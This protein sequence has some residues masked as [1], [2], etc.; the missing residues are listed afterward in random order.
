RHTPQGGRVA[1][2]L[3]AAEDQVAVQ[4]AD[5]GCGIAA[6]ELPHVFDRFYQ[7]NKSERNA[8]GGV[9]LGLAISKRIL[10]LHASTIAVNSSPQAGTQ[11]DFSLPAYA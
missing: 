4:V 2:T 11:F 6:E 5:T 10:D 3:T 8:S 7:V 9:G 1:V